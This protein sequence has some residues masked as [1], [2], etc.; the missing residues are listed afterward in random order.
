MASLALN[1]HS[2]G[3]EGGRV[4]YSRKGRDLKKQ[5]MEIEKRSGERKLALPQGRNLE[6]GGSEWFRIREKHSS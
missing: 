5:D 3:G 2:A 1:R 6:R 4:S